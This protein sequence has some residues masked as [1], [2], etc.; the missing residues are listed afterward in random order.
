M[1]G[2]EKTMGNLTLFDALTIDVFVLAVCIAI[3]IREARSA[4]HPAWM[5]IGL[6]AYIVTLRLLQL[7]TG[8]HPM[9]A[10]F[11]WPVAVDEVI[12]AGIASDVGLLAIAAGWIAARSVRKRMQIKRP[13]V[14]SV[15][16]FRIYFASAMAIV[17]GVFGAL[18]V[19]RLEHALRNASWDTSGYLAATT[20]W[21]AWSVCLLHFLFGFPPAL[22]AISTLVLVFVAITN[23]S[24]FAVV[25]SILFLT[26]TWLSRRPGQ[27]LPLGLVVGI[28]VAWMAWL[29]MKPLTRML[30][31]GS[32]FEDALTVA[33]QDTYAQFG[34]EE[35]SIDAQFL[36][37][38]GATMTLA[39]VHGGW[40]WGRTIAPLFV[41][42]VPR[43]FWPEKP[44]INQYQW[45]IQVP[46]RN[47]A[48]LGMT[49]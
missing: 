42:P 43:V 15:S 21:P 7:Y 8:S 2:V 22:V 37:M 25:I 14:V 28:A 19:G 32:R 35:G 17:V 41:C 12:R 4:L 29:P 9:K 24:R 30:N 5:F 26:F 47:M 13:R 39:D 44:K 10:T 36:D 45:D 11:E 40:Y 34:T 31:E 3:A 6:H 23:A 18:T 16:K 33:V 48:D 49:S 38:A 20:S 46:S 1:I 27:R